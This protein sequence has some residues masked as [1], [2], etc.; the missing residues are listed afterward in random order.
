MKPIPTTSSRLKFL[1]IALITLIGAVGFFGPASEF[2][3]VAG[4][5][6]GPTPGVTGAPGEVNC[7]A[8]HG[9]FPVN[10]GTGSVQISGIPKNYRPG[11]AIPITVTLSQSDGVIWG[12]QLT[13]LDSLGR[14]IGTYT[15][16]PATPAVLQLENGFINGQDRQY[17][18]HTINGTS[19]PVFGSKTWNFTWTAPAQ[20]AGKIGFY[21]AG[22]AANSDG[23]PGDDRIYTSSQATL[24][25][26]AI[27]SFDNDLKSDVSVF[28][29][30]NGVWYSVNSSN[31]EFKAVQFGLQGDIIAPGDYDGDGTTDRAVFRPSNGV[32]YIEKSTGGYT[33]VQWGAS[34]DIPVVGDYDGDLK[35][36]FAV[37]R[38]STGV[39][40]IVRSSD[41]GFDFRT[42]GISTDKNA[43]GDFDGDAKT[44]LAVFRPSEGVWY[45]WRSGD[46]GFSIFGFGLPGDRPVQSD[47]DG[48]G[49][50][51]AAVFRP[52][53]GVWYKLGSTQGFTSV[54]FGLSNDKP[55]P[56]DYDGDG[57]T[58]AAVYRDGIWYILRTTDSGVSIIGFGL[59]GD[60]PIPAG[61]IAP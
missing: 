41:G 55:A 57:L 13:A 15:I 39:W 49:R 7:T 32:W 59:P 6:H 11:Q 26:T 53:D 20:R 58:D 50:T 27:A 18:M 37:W 33:I 61:Y 24:S 34:G 60:V 4:S 48:D 5:A 10:S 9:T 29:P 47:Y 8:C 38:P 28:R 22:N 23:G 16:P 40:Y 56:A 14:R 17:I 44:D 30:S 54:Q 2:T 19:S 51:D 45:I 25:G 42:F 31:D 3:P 1:S 36:D 52:S 21:V 43:Q 46:G 35:S 12:F